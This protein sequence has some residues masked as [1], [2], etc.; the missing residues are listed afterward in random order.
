MNEWNTS[1]RQ[2]LR[3]TAQ[4]FTAKEIIP[5]LATWEQEGMI[6]RELHQSAARAGLLGIGWEEALGGQGGNMIDATVLTEA[7]IEAGASSGLASGLF[8]HAI[9]LPHI[10]DSG[11]DDLKVKYVEPTLTGVKI[12]SLGITEPGGGSD[13]ANLTTRAERDGDEFV[14]NGSKTF[15]TSGIRADFVTTAVRTGDAS[16]GAHGISLI[17]IDKDTEGFSVSKPLRKMGWLCSDT[18]ELNFANVRVPVSNLVGQENQGFYY[19]AQQFV[20]ERLWLAIQSYATA[21]RCLDLTVQYAKERETFGKPLIKNQVI[22]HKL[23]E[24]YRLT[25]TARVYTRS[26]VERL[27]EQGPEGKASP[28]LIRDAVLAKKTAVDAVE[29]VAHEAIQIH[30][31]MGYMRESEVE[32]HYRDMR[33]MGIGGGATEVL[34]ELAAKLMGY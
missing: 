33:I 4:D 23:A 9:A 20:S 11:S 30:G 1:E 16:S 31:G 34:D 32:M 13:V 8:T 15:I 28:D 21:Q 14:I 22:R 3:A 29:K 25:D 2:V 26:V 10:V 24:M 19:I 5:N 27:V 12:G 6:P 17:V 7:M 18:A